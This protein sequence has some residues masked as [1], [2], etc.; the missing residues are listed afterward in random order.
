MKENEIKGEGK[1]E[2]AQMGVIHLSSFVFFLAVW[3][4]LS[5][6]LFFLFKGNYLFFSH[7]DPTFTNI[8]FYLF[9]GNRLFFSR[10][11]LTFTISFEGNVFSLAVWTPFSQILFFSFLFE[12]NFQQ[13]SHKNV[14]SFQLLIL[15]FLISV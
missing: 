5:Q 2:M 13:F 12:G 15:N 4:P 1:W 3:I 8:F 14:N 6:I 10:V 11:N 7:V 9:E